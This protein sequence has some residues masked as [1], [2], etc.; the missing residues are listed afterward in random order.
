MRKNGQ[1]ANWTRP[2]GALRP[3][4]RFVRVVAATLAFIRRDS[5]GSVP[6]GEQVARCAPCRPL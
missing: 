4:L 6:K 3:S 1:A 2:Q 5:P